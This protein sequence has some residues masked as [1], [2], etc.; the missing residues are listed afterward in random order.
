MQF[1]S[2]GHSDVG[3]VREKNEDSL[4]LDDE[5]GIF[6]VADGVGGLPFGDLASRLAVKF[7]AALVHDSDDCSTIEELRQI[8][9][10]IHK[11][12]VDCGQLVGGENGIATTFSAVRLLSDKFIFSHVGDS[13]IFLNQGSGF[14]KISKCHTL[15]DELIDKH[16]PEAANDMPE[17]Y[18]HTL[19]RCMGQDI[20]FEVDLGEHQV[21]PG[22]QI[23][24]CSDGVKNMLEL[25]EI[26]ELGSTLGSKEFVHSLIDS[27]N[28]K[29]GVDNST[30][31]SIRIS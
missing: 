30:A 17:H 26:D 25:D 27:A 4:L 16:G 12:I 5:K 20:D 13:L 18:M 6:C 21:N 31:V 9:S 10:L 29:G 19:T 24:I 14:Q 15:G 1:T 2:Y 28:Q 8:S 3:F 7:F 22:D 11:D 23:L